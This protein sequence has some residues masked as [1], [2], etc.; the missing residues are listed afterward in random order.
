MKGKSDDESR[1]RRHFLKTANWLANWP[2][3]ELNAN[4][5]LIPEER[6]RERDIRTKIKFPFSKRED[7]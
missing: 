1:T 7:N 3:N 5:D 4:N 6:E 2:E